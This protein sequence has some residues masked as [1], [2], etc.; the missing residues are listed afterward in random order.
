MI[1]HTWMVNGG[2]KIECILD[3]LL[4]ISR[5]CQ[6]K[7]IPK[8]RSNNPNLNISRFQLL[9]SIYENNIKRFPMYFECIVVTKWTGLLQRYRVEL[10]YGLTFMA[11][12]SWSCIYD[13]HTNVVMAWNPHMVVGKALETHVPIL[14]DLPCWEGIGNTCSHSW[15]PPMLGAWCSHIGTCVPTSTFPSFGNVMFPCWN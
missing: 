5:F 14:E 2:I 9:I 6:K 7:K 8:K 1:N 4:M 3:L 10:C 15:G 11:C 13:T 12:V